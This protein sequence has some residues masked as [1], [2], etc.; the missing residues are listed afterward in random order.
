MELV[1]L[2]MIKVGSRWDLGMKPKV[3]RA[4]LDRWEYM[5][6]ES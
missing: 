3:V 1:A 2:G 6:Q 4:D 5:A